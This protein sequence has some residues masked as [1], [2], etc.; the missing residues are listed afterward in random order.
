MTDEPIEPIFYEEDGN[1]IIDTITYMLEHKSVPRMDLKLEGNK[2]AKV[3][4]AGTVLRI[5]IEGLR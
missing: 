1:E 4:W 2:T 5:D 3:Y